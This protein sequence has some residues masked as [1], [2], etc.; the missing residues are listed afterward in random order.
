MFYSGIVINILWLLVFS[1]K[2]HDV[3]KHLSLPR[4]IYLIDQGNGAAR[5]EDKYLHETF[6]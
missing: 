5:P 1:N 3:G 2:S 6:T 4:C